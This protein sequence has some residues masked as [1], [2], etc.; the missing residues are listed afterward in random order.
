MEADIDMIAEANYEDELNRRAG[1]F[2]AMLLRTVIAVDEETK[3]A[4]YVKSGKMGHHGV[5]K[6]ILYK[7][8]AFVA[9]EIIDSE[10]MNENATDKKKDSVKAQTIGTTCRDAFRLPVERTAKGWVVILDKHKLDIGK[11]RFGLRDMEVM[12]EPA[13]EITQEALSL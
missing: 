11:L 4:Q 2:E 12:G 10:N 7:D 3:Y 6:Y 9:N 5:V 8:L 13:K 1:S